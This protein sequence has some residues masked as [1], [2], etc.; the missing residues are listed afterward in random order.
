MAP[1]GNPSA[2][3]HIE[4][5]GIICTVRR[6]FAISLNNCFGSENACVLLSGRGAMNKKFFKTV[7]LI[8]SAFL[9]AAPPCWA[10]AKGYCYVVAYSYKIKKVFFSPVFMEKVRD[11][12]YSDEEYCT[13]VDLIQK[14]E[15]QFQS[16]LSANRKVDV[17][18]YTITA[19]G[20]YKNEGVALKRFMTE[21]EDYTKKG[22]KASVLKG[23]VYKN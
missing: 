6:L 2:G 11:A 22:F 7:L 21:R 3:R 15:S 9:F 10:K 17:S 16:H 13:D 20:A 19:R 23:F 8:L 12:S 1:G 18:R 14:M 5:E 4:V